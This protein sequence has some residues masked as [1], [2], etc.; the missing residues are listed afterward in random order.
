MNFKCRIISLT[1]SLEIGKFPS[2][3]QRF[4]GMGFT[5][6]SGLEALEIRLGTDLVYIPRIRD[7]LQP[8]GDR[9]LRRIYTIAEQQACGL[10]VDPETDRSRHWSVVPPPGSLTI[11]QPAGPPRKPWLKR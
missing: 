9:F 5:G 10:T 4:T 7:A 3:Y 11:W 6:I 2:R 1:Q 8:F